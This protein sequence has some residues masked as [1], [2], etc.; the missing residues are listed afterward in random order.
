[1]SGLSIKKWVEP[2]VLL[3]TLKKS[4]LMADLTFDGFSKLNQ[5]DVMLNLIK[6]SD[7]K[8]FGL[9]MKNVNKFYVFSSDNSV[10]VEDILSKIGVDKDEAELFDDY[11]I[12]VNEVD[13]ARA[14][15]GLIFVD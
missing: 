12:P 9:Y 2:Y 5:K 15:A 14:E 10:N 3:E 8:S 1:M 6:K 4:Y 13:M 7:N 11:N